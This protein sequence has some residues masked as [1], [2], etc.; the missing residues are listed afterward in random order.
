[1]SVPIVSTALYFAVCYAGLV[2]AAMTA[3]GA[4]VIAVV[5][6][7]SAAVRVQLDQWAA[8]QQLRQRDRLRMRRVEVCGPARAHQYRELSDLVEEID[9]VDAKA[10]NRYELE[11]LLDQFV[12]TSRAHH[13]C[14]ESL[15][16][17]PTGDAPFVERSR[18]RGDIQARRVRRREESTQRIAELS[19]QL[20]AID[21]M[22][23]L[24]AHSV[25]SSSGA[26]DVPAELERRMWELDEVD[27]AMAQIAA[28]HGEAA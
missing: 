13:R 26:S 4:I 9:H 12:E 21:E 2:A 16:F 8:N 19:D 3:I 15:R 11:G 28:E 20:A 10:S 1:M 24:I 17:A 14:V 27:T 22:L 25:H 7:R 5:V 23:H 18:M 6:T